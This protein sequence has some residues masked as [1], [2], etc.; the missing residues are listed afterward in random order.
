MDRL[1]ILKFSA[2]AE[3]QAAVPYK[4]YGPKMQLLKFFGCGDALVVWPVVSSSSPAVA[5]TSTTVTFTVTRSGADLDTTSVVNYA[6]SNGT[7][8]AGQDYTA[9]SGTLTFL[10]GETSKT[11]VITI[12]NDELDE[13]P[14]TFSLVLSAP[15]NCTLGTNGVCTITSED[16]ASLSSL[17]PNTGYLLSAGQIDPNYTCY[18]LSGEANGVT[19]VGKAYPDTYY[20]AHNGQP[21]QYITSLVDSAT[22]VHGIDAFEAGVYKFTLPFNLYGYDLSTI[23]IS[24]LASADNSLVVKLNNIQIS[25]GDFNIVEAT[26]LNQTANTLEFF[27]TNLAGGGGYNPMWLSVEFT[28]RTGSLL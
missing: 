19:E 24:A 5:E 3:A 17:L 27:V 13:P 6:T 16:I 20:G 4:R 10:P 2:G 21:V 25:T 9:T 7:A 15:V 22:G 26:G 14:E 23:N 1:Q 11:I 28:T 8:T 18:K 12:L